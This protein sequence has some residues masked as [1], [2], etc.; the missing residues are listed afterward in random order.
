MGIY[1]HT[2]QLPPY[3]RYPEDGPEK[4]PLLGIP[5]SPPALHSRPPVL[6]T[7]PGMPLMHAHIQP[8]PQQSM[9]DESEL[10]RSNTRSSRTEASLRTG[11]SSHDS[12][13]T[14]KSWSEKSWREKRK[15][16]F[17][18]I[19]FWAFLVAL[20]CLTFIAV[21]LGAVIGGFVVDQQKAD[22]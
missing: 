21:V 6:G 14:K 7:D 16:R 22:K 12:L 3:T 11:D 19:P 9:T 18:G 15:T 20:G 5:D 2:E 8:A 10:Q 1:G 13:L 4:A 17:C